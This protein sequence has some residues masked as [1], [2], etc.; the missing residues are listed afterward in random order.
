[1]IKDYNGNKLPLKK[2]AKMELLNIILNNTTELNHTIDMS[3]MS[4]KEST[5]YLRHCEIQINRIK[6]LLETK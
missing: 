6:K 3:L 1:M 5:E 2:A 4:E